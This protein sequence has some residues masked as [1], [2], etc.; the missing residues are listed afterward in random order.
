MV[1][2]N[3]T[4]QQRAS[5]TMVAPIAAARAPPAAAT[6]HASHQSPKAAKLQK[7]SPRFATPVR[8]RRPVA[9]P[10]HPRSLR[11]SDRARRL[12]LT[13]PRPHRER[14]SR[15]DPHPRSPIARQPSPAR[16]RLGKRPP[17]RALRNASCHSRRPFRS[18]A[19]TFHPE[20]RVRTRRVTPCELE[21]GA[22]SPFYPVT[23]HLHCARCYGLTI[24]FRQKY[25][26]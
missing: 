5:P 18:S 13:A 6:A 22:L 8:Q 1:A 26:S 12:G 17:P 4:N 15:Y 23:L 24:H 9:L 11:P 25:P 3:G 10:G 16:P 2:R 20:D 19:P 14:R 7:P 21:I